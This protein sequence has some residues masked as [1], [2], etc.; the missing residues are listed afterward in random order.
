MRRAIWMYLEDRS[1]VIRWGSNIDNDKNSVDGR[2]LKDQNHTDLLKIWLYGEKYFKYSQ[3]TRSEVANSKAT[4]SERCASAYRRLLVLFM[5][6]WPL[7]LKEH[8]MSWNLVSLN[9]ML[10]ERTWIRHLTGEYLFGKEHMNTKELI[11][12]SLKADVT[13]NVVLSTCT[14]ATYEAK[15]VA[16][17]N[18][19]NS[20]KPRL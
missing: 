5:L 6:N 1:S 7:K 15:K 11:D 20:Y 19:I 10:T 12:S 3:L 2:N 9:I 14:V 8:M 17:I 4:S 18:W 16:Q 13:R